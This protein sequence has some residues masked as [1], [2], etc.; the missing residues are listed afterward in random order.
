VKLLQLGQLF[1]LPL[2]AAIRAQNLALQETI[3][4]I[5]EF[6]MEKGSARTFSLRAE[7]IVEERK[8]DPETGESK[9][10]IKEKPLELSIPLLA[11][12]PPPVM[13]LQE[14]D[15]EFGVEIVEPRTEP[16]KSSVISSALKGASLAPTLALFSPLGKSNPT[17]IRVKMKI[18]RDVPEG[19]ARLG[20]VLVDLLSGK[21]PSA[22]T[23]AQKKQAESSLPVEKI[24]GIGA[25]TADLLKKKGI[26]TVMDLI[27]ATKTNEGVKELAK[28]VGVSERRIL[29]WRK[30]AKLLA[31][32]EK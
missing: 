27:S 24:R 6:G 7:R 21:T 14:M 5:E 10:E 11:L 16:I 30:K 13:Q 3:S 15:V 26:A 31:E 18:T 22:S 2:Q 28:T 23:G 29:G 32:G 1:A 9:T 12:V 20:D 4:F 17:T 19:M 8:I 25:E